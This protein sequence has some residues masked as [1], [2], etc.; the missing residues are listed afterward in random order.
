[1]LSLSLYLGNPLPAV[2]LYLADRKLI[3]QRMIVRHSETGLEVL[4][5]SRRTV[6]GGFPQQAQPSKSASGLLGLNGNTTTTTSFTSNAFSGGD[7]FSGDTSTVNQS[8][9]SLA[10][11]R[12]PAAEHIN[13][14]LR[15]EA[16]NFDL[17]H[18][19]NRTVRID[20]NCKLGSANYLLHEWPPVSLS[21]SPPLSVRP[22]KTVIVDL[23]R[24][25]HSLTAGRSLS[26]TCIS[27]GS[28][29]AAR[30]R[31]FLNNRPLL[32]VK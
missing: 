28:R 13:A 27:W 17:K 10:L 7:P 2:S 25:N 11:L 30:I 21:L 15:C 4:G 22:R 31:W 26:V 18:P 9:L 5:G 1:M 14:T 16:V 12:S 24:N 8:V 3:P 23:P 20:V 6:K 29:P 32:D 19:L